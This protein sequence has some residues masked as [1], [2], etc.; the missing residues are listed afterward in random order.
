MKRPL[1]AIILFLLVGLHTSNAQDPKR[2]EAD[3]QK[4]EK[5]DQTNLS[6]GDIL[7]V[8][9][10][11]IRFWKSLQNDFPK[12][13]VINRGFGGSHMSDLLFYLDALVLK[14]KPKQIFIYEGDN[15]INDKESPKSILRE[16]KIIVQKI[17]ETLPKAEIVLISAK[18][19]IARWNFK[20]R[21][22]RLNRL[23]QNYAEKHSYLQFVDVWNP[24]LNEEGRPM[25]D[26]FIE[27]DLHMNA[28]GYQ[29]WK[30]VIEPYLK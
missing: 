14:Y 24:M 26:I 16:T 10:S 4:F 28:K 7:F 22:E 12:Y 27:D 21:Y 18:P 11:S 23:F 19:S 6:Q 2:F 13:K 1:I 29:I 25:P 15:D 20:K 9:S 30:E 17:R 3:I 5:L 8:G